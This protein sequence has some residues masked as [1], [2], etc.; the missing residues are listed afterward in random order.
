MNAEQKL[1]ERLNK[2]VTKMLLDNANSYD[3]DLFSLGYA[4]AT[5]S[6]RL[7]IE[8]ILECYFHEKEHEKD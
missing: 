6:F 1:L 2:K 7:D 8:A 3:E 5:E 4:S